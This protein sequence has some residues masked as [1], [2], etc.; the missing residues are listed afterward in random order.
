MTFF[1][2]CLNVF[3]QENERLLTK[4]EVKMFQTIKRFYKE[5][6]IPVK[7]IDILDKNNEIYKSQYV[8]NESQY[9][10][11]WLVGYGVAYFHQ[12]STLFYEMSVGTAYTKSGE[13]KI[14]DD[15]YIMTDYSYGTEAGEIKILV[16]GKEKYNKIVKF[17]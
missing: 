12:I 8:Y 3:S 9:K 16:N 10:E 5:I 17:K 14:I 11:D 7:A 15:E 2:V 13:I 4:E 6:K 1:L